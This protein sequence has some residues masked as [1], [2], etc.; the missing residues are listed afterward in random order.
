MGEAYYDKASRLLDIIHDLVESGKIEGADELSFTL[1]DSD[2]ICLHPVL[3]DELSKNSNQDLL[4][5]AEANI[6]DLF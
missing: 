3:Q 5:W 6:K 1:D 4:E 2:G